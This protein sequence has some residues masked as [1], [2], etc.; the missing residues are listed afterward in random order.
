MKGIK[1]FYI[2]I[3]WLGTFLTLSF[4]RSRIMIAGVKYFL[5][6]PRTIGRTLLRLVSQKKNNFAINCN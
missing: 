1:I 3:C 4:T 6:E 5:K 2:K